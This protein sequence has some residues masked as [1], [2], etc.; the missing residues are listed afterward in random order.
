VARTT[1]VAAYEQLHA[2]G[3]VESRVGAGTWV[4]P[5]LRQET[6]ARIRRG[7][8]A[9][10]ADTA[11]RARRSLDDTDIAGQSELA[12]RPFATGVCAM[13]AASQRAWRRLVVRRLGTI[14]SAH[15]GYGDPF[16]S[17]EL[18]TALAG[19]LR[20]ARSVI[21]DPAQ[22]AIVSGTQ[23]GIDLALR[24]L[25]RPGDA[26]WIEDPCYPGAAGA[27]RQYGL[28]LVPVPVD[29]KGL[30]VAAGLRRA[31]QARLAYVTP[32]HQYPLGMAMHM[33][34]RLALLRWAKEA[35]AWI[36]EDDYDS[37]FRFEGRPQSALQ[38]LDAA[39][40]VIHIGSLSKVLFPGLRLGY[41]VMPPALIERFAQARH[42]S[43]RFPASLVHDVVTDFI[44]EGSFTA[45]IRRTRALYARSRDALAA[46]ADRHLAPVGT[47]APADRGMHLLLCLKPGLDDRQAAEA[48][49]SAGV[50][51][52]PLSPMYLGRK[53]RHGLLLGFTGFARPALD[54]AVR[55]LAQ[56][57]RRL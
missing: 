22:I 17:L 33:S 3:V 1:T 14:G 56:A 51:T 20:V 9:R 45:H 54:E 38:G 49:A 8:G 27:F 39:G 4:A 50:V 41:V 31:P 37:E 29:E 30:D 36:I 40:H 23:H 16:G 19:Y 11:S 32:S 44:L 35:G 7:D 12:R 5:G 53:P 47:I 57:L 13:P 18:R 43:D 15:L 25:S 26:A 48:A 34:R 52:K 46:M 42:L 55:R 6:P 10:N 2:E 28:D 24:V 21:C